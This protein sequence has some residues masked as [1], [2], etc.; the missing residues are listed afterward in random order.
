MTNDLSE[1][2]ADLQKLKA[3][4]TKYEPYADLMRELWAD[5]TEKYCPLSLVFYRKNKPK[6]RSVKN[7]QTQM[8]NVNS[9]CSVVMVD[10]NELGTIKRILKHKGFSQLIAIL[11]VTDQQ[12]T[13]P[14]F[15]LTDPRYKFRNIHELALT[16]DLTQQEAE[17]LESQYPSKAWGQLK[18][19]L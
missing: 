2:E 13:L 5:L 16:H 1:W 3:E 15:A 8:Q 19:F 18:M 11:D 10:F 4:L 6:L 9:Y 17:W 12:K 7:P 14:Y